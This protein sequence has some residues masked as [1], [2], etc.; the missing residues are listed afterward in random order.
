MFYSSLTDRKITDKG[1]EYILWNKFE[2][3]TKK[4]HQDLYLKCD[5]LLL[6][7]KFRKIAE[8]TMDCVQ[9]IVWVHQV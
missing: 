1:N 5:T 7:E 2:I 3:K 6:A 4:D 8:K 9:V